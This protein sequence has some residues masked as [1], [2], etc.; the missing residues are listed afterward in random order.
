MKSNLII[1]SPQTPKNASLQSF[2]TEQIHSGKFD[3]AKVAVAYATVSGV[4]AMLAAFE[5]QGLKSSH[6]LIGLDDSVTQPGAIELLLT[7]KNAEVR[8]ASFKQYHFRFHPKFFTFSCKKKNNKLLALVGSANLT[9]SALFGNCEAVAVLEGQSKSDRSIID[10]AWDTLWKQGHKPDSEELD[11]Y[12]L[13][14]KKATEL[15][16]EYKNNF[17]KKQKDTGTSE[18]L[19]SD[20]AELDPTTA[21]IC[22]IECGK[23]TAMGRELELKSEQGLFFGLNPSGGGEK[24]IA[25]TT[26]DEKQTNLKMKYQGNKMWRLQMNNNVPEVKDGLRPKT[27]DGKLGRSPY[28]AVFSR[29]T[30]NKTIGLKFLKIDSDEFKILREQTMESGTLGKTIVREYG[31]CSYK[32]I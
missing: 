14:Y 1:Q 32:N 12:K 24:D 28:V 8:V 10:E 25:I 6:W 15:D 23:V 17:A 26:S 20:N 16:K 30:S 2:I 13:L 18:I 31:W 5:K 19:A 7:L 27:K 11:E 3:C 22:W 21:D 4:R 29:N 9:A